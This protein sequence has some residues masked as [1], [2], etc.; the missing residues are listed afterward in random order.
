MLRSQPTHALPFSTNTAGKGGDERRRHWWQGSGESRGSTFFRR[1]CWA[2]W[3]V[4]ACA[5]G[6]GKRIKEE[7]MAEMAGFRILWGNSQDQ[8][9][10]DWYEE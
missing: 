3:I 4:W 8:I 7:E 9:G 2:G 5:G 6:A 1:L 10:W